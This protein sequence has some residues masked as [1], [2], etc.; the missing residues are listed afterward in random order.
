MRKL[1]EKFWNY[2]LENDRRWYVFVIVV[3][4]MV[5]FV[6][7]VLQQCFIDPLMLQLRAR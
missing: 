4:A 3:C 6:L 2:L 1:H 7:G 5:G